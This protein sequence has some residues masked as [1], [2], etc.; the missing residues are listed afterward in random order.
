MKCE[1]CGKNLGEYKCSICNKIIC[2]DCKTIVNKKIVCIDHPKET[3][4]PPK[5]TSLKILKKGIMAVFIIL[6]GVVLI[7][8]IANYY[9]IK[10]ELPPEISQ[11]PAI[12][13]ILNLF[14]SFGL[15]LIVAI[16]M[17]LVLLIVTFVILRRRR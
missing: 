10:L 2:S 4:K 12:M 17:V 15:H 11:V 5:K 16:T 3:A 6:V 8:F 7:F 13:D 1:K 14:E 9:I